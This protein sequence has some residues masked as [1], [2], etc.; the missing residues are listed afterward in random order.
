MRSAV[1]RG[2]TR[3]CFCFLPTATITG[4]SRSG[5]RGARHHAVVQ[6]G[7]APTDAGAKVHD[8]IA[9]N[10]RD[11]LGL[12]DAPKRSDT[13][14]LPLMAEAPTPPREP[15]CRQGS[16]FDPPAADEAAN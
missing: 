10:A 14:Q 2:S 11:P 12:L 8:G 9:V 7:I 5:G 1:P 4:P 6:L 16:L 13:L 15:D 3:L